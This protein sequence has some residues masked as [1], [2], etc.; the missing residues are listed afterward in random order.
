MMMFSLALALAQ[1][2]PGAAASAGHD[3]LEL[4]CLE[5]HTGAEAEAG[6][7]IASMLAADAD[8]Q[9]PFMSVDI[10]AQRYYSFVGD[11]IAAGGDEDAPSPEMQEAM[12]DAMNALS[13]MY[14]RMTMNVRFTSRGVEMDGDVTIAD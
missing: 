10:D 13:D 5:C 12:Q 7:D 9:P 3:V 8:E 1:A 6:F 2:G 11:A 4:V 14:G